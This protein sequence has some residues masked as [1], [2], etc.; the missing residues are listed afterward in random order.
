V[1]RRHVAAAAR[2][3]QA[4]LPRLAGHLPPHTMR[5]LL[6]MATIP[7]LPLAA[8]KVALW[9]CMRVPSRGWLH[10]LGLVLRG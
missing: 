4:L 2:L 1:V 6:R 9:Q 5:Q 7:H 10:H 8:R 3:A